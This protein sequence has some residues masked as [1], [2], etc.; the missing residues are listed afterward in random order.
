[1][2]KLTRHIEME[3]KIIY[4]F[5]QEIHRGAGETM[6]YIDGLITLHYGY[7]PDMFISLEEIQVYIEVCE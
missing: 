2:A 7:R 3:T 1:M 4:S 6:D 5:K